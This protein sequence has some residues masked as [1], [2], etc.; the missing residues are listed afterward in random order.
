MAHIE[1]SGDSANCIH[2]NMIYGPTPHAILRLYTP[3]MDTSFFSTSGWGKYPAFVSFC[4]EV[5]P[6]FHRQIPLAKPSH[7][8]P[9]G[10]RGI[11]KCSAYMGSYFLATV[12]H[13]EREL[14]IP[15]IYCPTLPLK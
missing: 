14:E 5:T 1:S 11:G 6:D 12:L 3:C 8:T 15:G 7:I 9:Y 10:G 4:L 13:Y 2:L